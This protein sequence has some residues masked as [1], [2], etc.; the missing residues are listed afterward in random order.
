MA[1]ARER[2]GAGRQRR[3]GRPDEERRRAA[4][5]A[6]ES[7]AAMSSSVEPRRV[8]SSAA[9]R[10]PRLLRRRALGIV[11][12]HVVSA[13]EAMDELVRSPSPCAKPPSSGDATLASQPRPPPSSA[14]WRR[15]LAPRRVRVRVASCSHRWAPSTRPSA[16]QIRGTTLRGGGSRGI[17]S[18]VVDGAARLRHRVAAA[19]VL[20]PTLPVVAER[21]VREEEA[22]SP[23][24]RCRETRERDEDGKEAEKRGKERN[25][26]GNAT[27][28]AHVGP[29][30]SPATSRQTG[31]KTTLGPQATVLLVQGPPVSGFA[32]GE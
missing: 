28:G 14:P 18:G 4:S 32:V 27:G 3:Q 9:V 12:A 5:A 6:V 10:A 21:E 22:A 11:A 23:M 30:D 13:M 7:R 20:L 16:A 31:V 1:V 17:P 24:R 15:L 29:A 26:C 19:G 8:A 2:S 25:L